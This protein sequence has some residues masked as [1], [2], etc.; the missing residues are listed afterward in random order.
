MTADVAS[1]DSPGDE[2]VTAYERD[3]VMCLRQAA[4]AGW[5]AAIEQG[6][7]EALTG[8]SADLDVLQ[9]RGDTGRFSFSSQAWRQVE[10][11]RRFI[12]ESSL[13]DLCW[14]F[15]RSQTLTLF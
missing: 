6:I 12:F 5:L 13:P 4:D 3:G 14:P 2:A 8:G 9:I 11:F 15:L 1:F 7:D 10:P